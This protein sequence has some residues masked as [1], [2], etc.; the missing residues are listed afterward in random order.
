MWLIIIL[1]SASCGNG[2]PGKA[3]SE[4]LIESSLDEVRDLMSEDELR[5]LN[6][7]HESELASVHFS[8][9]LRIRNQLLSKESILMRA[10]QELGIRQRDDASKVLLI[11]LHRGLK[12]KAINVNE[13]VSNVVS[14]DSRSERY[15]QQNYGA[16]TLSELEPVLIHE[17]SDDVETTTKSFELS[18]CPIDRHVWKFTSR[19]GWSLANQEEAAEALHVF[20]RAFSTNQ[21][22]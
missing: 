8:L 6:K 22:Q 13:I 18:V 10:F 9:G 17:E 4:L 5:Q 15:A 19:E 2:N 12:K 11:M 1:L 7:L 16:C 3:D 21:D 20:D 14:R